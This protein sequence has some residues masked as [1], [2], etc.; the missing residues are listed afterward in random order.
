MVVLDGDPS[1]ASLP[2]VIRGK[3]PDGYRVPPHWHPTDE[4][5]VVLSGSFSVGTGDAF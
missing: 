2:F 1:R 5:I 4:N 3:F